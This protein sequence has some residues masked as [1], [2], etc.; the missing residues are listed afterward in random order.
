TDRGAAERE[1]KSAVPGGEGGANG[2]ADGCGFVC[3]ARGHRSRACER[4]SSEIAGCEFAVCRKP[5]GEAGA[6]EGRQCGGCYGPICAR[7]TYH[8]GYLGADGC[9]RLAEIA[10]LECD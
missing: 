3:R 5:G 7:K 6:L 8:A 4:T 2:A 1:S 9:G 10:F